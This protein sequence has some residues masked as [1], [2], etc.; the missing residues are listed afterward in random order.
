MARL[1]PGDRVYHRGRDEHG[2]YEA[3]TNDSTAYLV[4]FE[5]SP[6]AERVSAHLVEPAAKQKPT[7][8]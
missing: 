5:G 3:R 6:E 1:K 7:T 4:T 2:T 8:N